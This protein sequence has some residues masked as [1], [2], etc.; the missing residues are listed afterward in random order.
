MSA[1]LNDSTANGIEENDPKEN[2][3][4]ANATEENGV[5]ENEAEYTN[6]PMINECLQAAVKGDVKAFKEFLKNEIIQN[7]LTKRYFRDIFPTFPKAESLIFG[8]EMGSEE[9]KQTSENKETSEQVDTKTTTE[10]SVT[11]TSLQR[12]EGIRELLIHLL[13]WAIM[14]RENFQKNSVWRSVAEIVPEIKETPIL[15]IV[16]IVKK[17]QFHYRTLLWPNTPLCSVLNALFPGCL[18]GN[19]AENY[20]EF[21]QGLILSGNDLIKSI[22][23]NEVGKALELLQR[24]DIKKIAADEENVALFLS[25]GEEL[26][27]VV[28]RL[29][30]IPEV[31][32]DTVGLARALEQV[33][34]H[35]QLEMLLEFLKYP[36][37]LDNVGRLLRMDL[38]QW[39]Q[40]WT[41]YG[42]DQDSWAVSFQLIKTVFAERPRSLLPRSP[43][44]VETKQDSTQASSLNFDDLMQLVSYAVEY[45]DLANFQEFVRLPGVRDN[46]A[47]DDNHLLYQTTF[48]ND[49]I[50]D[51]QMNIKNMRN[52]L[53]I[54]S[55]WLVFLLLLKDENVQ[56][57][58][59]DCKFKDQILN[60]VLFSKEIGLCDFMLKFCNRNYIALPQVFQKYAELSKLISGGEFSQKTLIDGMARVVELVYDQ[61]VEDAKLEHEG[62]NKKSNNANNKNSANI[63]NDNKEKSEYQDGTEA[64]LV[65]LLK[66]ENHRAGIAGTANHLM[67]QFAAMKGYTTLIGKLLEIKE[68]ADN[69]PVIGEALRIA[70]KTKDDAALKDNPSLNRLLVKMEDLLKREALPNEPI[71]MDTIQRQILNQGFYHAVYL[72]D[73]DR[74][75]KLMKSPVFSTV[76]ENFE[77]MPLL[78]YTALNVA[79]AFEQWAVI[80]K[81]L[82]FSWT[83]HALSHNNHRILRMA[84]EKENATILCELVRAYQETKTDLPK[85]ESNK[86]SDTQETKGK[87]ETKT[88]SAQQETKADLPKELTYAG[89]S[90]STLESQVTQTFEQCSTVGATE[91]FCG[92]RFPIGLTK[93]I[94]E[95]SA[96][97]TH[98]DPNAPLLLFC[99]P[100]A[101][102]VDAGSVGAEF[103][104]ADPKLF[105]P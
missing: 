101:R 42:F 75:L 3:V 79:F 46:L 81:L 98:Q 43:I 41:Q 68:V 8:C 24:E 30:E 38:D 99:G 7:W 83:K 1:Q 20:A 63:S 94:F 26:P 70:C 97:T 27:T 82:Q 48:P 47:W 100:Y 4:E 49:D 10:T 29:L 17:Y 2:G 37:V 5:E 53:K 62:T 71:E 55:R 60:N 40:S 21:V 92:T 89:T 35:R 11:K 28:R 32:Q 67:L 95:M 58:F 103:S 72:G 86:H 44:S 73:W 84:M 104:A 102:R 12:K 65:E 57:R 33:I 19:H 6:H 61:I 15:D 93:L 76:P 59:K 96:L 50:N 22:N 31:R 45:G 9:C 54:S 51:D 105:A 78:S 56:K 25:V 52:A 23:R 88:D 14:V 39:R 77:G 36:E 91:G 18:L 90:L 34:L 69:K 74:V 80:P 13:L 85:Q 64:A 16:Y 87:Q 66:D